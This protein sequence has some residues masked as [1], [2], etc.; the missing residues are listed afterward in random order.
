ML[1]FMTSLLMRGTAVRCGWGRLVHDS[2]RFDAARSLP[3]PA[4][5]GENS[6]HGDLQFM[7][8]CRVASVGVGTS[9]ARSNVPWVSIA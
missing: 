3:M 8:N 6:V 2:S 1:R 4:P 9:A 7:P 5:S